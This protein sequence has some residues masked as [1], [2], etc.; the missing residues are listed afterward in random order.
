MKYLITYIVIAVIFQTIYTIISYKKA[1][2]KFKQK[3]EYDFL[4]HFYEDFFSSPSM[5]SLKL[6]IWNWYTIMFVFIPMSIFICQFLFPFS[7]LS[8]IKKLLGYKSKLQKEVDIEEKEM[9]E[10]SKKHDEFMRTESDINPNMEEINK[11]KNRIFL[12]GTC[13]NSTWRNELMQSVQV[14]MFNPVVEDWTPECQQN[15]MD[16]KE[17][18]CNIHFYCITKEMTGVFS[19]AEVI[20][21]V[22]NKKVRTILHVIP[23]EFEQKQLKSLQ[24]VVDLVN[25]RGG[26]AYIDSELNRS[27]RLLNYCFKI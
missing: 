17:N 27:A 2:K 5:R 6:K 16:E 23:D 14:D 1:L 19:I 20:D 10:A 3:H 7:L 15:E 12:G 18:K 13:N 11:M 25:L 22:H 24:A 26:I 8:I 21:S 4:K 9:D